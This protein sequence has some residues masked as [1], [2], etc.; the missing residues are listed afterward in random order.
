ML[1]THTHTHSQDLRKAKIIESIRLMRTQGLATLKNQNYPNDD[2]E[3]ITLRSF[4]AKTRVANRVKRE[5]HL[6]VSPV[7]A[8]AQPR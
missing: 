2:A 7:P 8:L 5:H 4:S 3:R 6:S 1:H